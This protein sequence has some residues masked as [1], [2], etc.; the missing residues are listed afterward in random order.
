VTGEL[1]V[2]QLVHGDTVIV[3][4]DRDAIDDLIHSHRDEEGDA[5]AV[6][7]VQRPA[8]SATGRSV[9]PGNSLDAD[10]RRRVADAGATLDE[11]LSTLLARIREELAWN[12]A[13]GG[14]P[15]RLGMHDGLRFAEDAVVNLLRHHGHVVD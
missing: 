9:P 11:G 2:P 12:D 10:Q 1:V 13:R 7:P 4:Y 3:G 14:A 6:S 15:Y 5:A 8:G